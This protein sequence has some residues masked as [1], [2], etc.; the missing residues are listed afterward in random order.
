M[1]DSVQEIYGVVCRQYLRWYIGNMYPNKWI[2]YG[3]YTWVV[4]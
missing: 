3:Q 1:E 4:C 2:V